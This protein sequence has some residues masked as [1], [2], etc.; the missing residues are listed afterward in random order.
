VARIASF[1][2]FDLDDVGSE[3]SK[4]HAGQ[5]QVMVVVSSITQRP[6]CRPAALSHHVPFPL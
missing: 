4:N 6:E 5:W 1:G 2:I 3:I